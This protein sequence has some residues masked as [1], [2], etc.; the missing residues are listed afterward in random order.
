MIVVGFEFYS[1]GCTI[2][3]SCLQL[4]IMFVILR[5]EDRDSICIRYTWTCSCNGDE[6]FSVNNSYCNIFLR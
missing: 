6:T 5:R 2:Y 3:P 1:S 4:V